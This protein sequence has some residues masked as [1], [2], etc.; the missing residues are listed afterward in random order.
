MIERH[1]YAGLLCSLLLL[2]ACGGSGGSS[3]LN[4]QPVLVSAVFIGATSTPTAGDR[5]QLI[6]SEDVML[7]GGLVLD[8][9]DVTLSGGTLGSIAAAPTLVSARVVEVVLGAGVTFTPGTTTIDFNTANDVVRDTTGILVEASSPRVITD[10]DADDPTV[11]SLTLNGIVG[12]LN[13][14]GPAGGTLQVPPNG[15]TIDLTYSDTSSAVDPA[16]TLVAVDV[17]TTAGG[18]ARAAGENLL[19]DLTVVTASASAASYLVPA[20]L[21]MPGLTINMT[22]QVT[23]TSGRISA[24]AVF[25]F[26]VTFLTNAIRPFETIVNPSQLWYVDFSRDLE[27]YTVN[28]LNNIT[29]VQVNNSANSNP[30]ILDLLGTIGLQHSSPILNVIGSKDSNEVVFDQFRAEVLSQLGTLFPGVNIT[31]TD[32]SPGPFPAPSGFTDYNSAAFSQMCIAG[33]FDVAGTSG[34]LGLSL[35][36]DNNSGQENNCLEDFQGSRLGVFL[37]TIVNSGFLQSP[38]SLFRQTYDPF[39]PSR[40]GMPIGADAADDQ[41]LTNVLNDGRASQIDL[42]IQRMARFAAVVAGHEMGHSMGLVKNGPMPAGLYAND[43]TNFP[44]SSDSHIL[45]PASIFTGGAI[46]LMTPAL[47]FEGTLVPTTRLNT[48]NL[49][50]LREQALYNLP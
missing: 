27:S 34:V 45:M 10:G 5:L 4:L 15:F 16:Q 44:G 24:P 39:T 48:L 19:A 46:N 36:D 14:S 32:V 35:F 7:T 30:D 8:D 28:L 37:H 13:G 33:S 42:A 25:A 20:A 18:G 6:M 41:R 22:V 40:S 2:P 23:D 31:F 9:N 3:A 26:K 50:Y 1:C 49:A 29:P 38:V 12:L 11:D 21:V 47:S 43:P 17:Q